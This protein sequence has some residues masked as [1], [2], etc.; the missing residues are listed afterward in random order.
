MKNMLFIVNPRSGKMRMRN[1]LL[2]VVEVFCRAGYNVDI[3]TTLHRC[4]ATEIAADADEESTDIIALSG[5]DGTL[6]EVITGLM[7]SK[8]KI[9]VGYIPC[10]STNDFAATFGLD[11]DIKKAAERIV[12]GK[13]FPIDIGSFSGEKY[14]SYIASFGMF[15]SVSYST[16][17]AV[18]NTFGHIAYIFSGMNDITKIIPYHVIV[19]AD[20]KRYE[21]DYI[22]GSVT[23]T[24]SVGGIVKFDSS[25]VEMNDG[26]FE[27]VLVKKPLNL[28]DLNKIIG[29]LITSNFNDSVFE[30]IKSAHISMTFSGDM[31]WSLDGEHVRSGSS[32]TIENIHGAANIIK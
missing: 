2:D 29:G 27:T 11:T 31:D 28:N 13:P 32:V 5:G 4:H 23:N 12:T 1:Y 26:I 22:F 20:G 3:R 9:P 30:F 24:T 18:K 15:T 25:L 17:Q 16:P 14:F 19:D 10:G 7:Q 21:G 6:N 8:K